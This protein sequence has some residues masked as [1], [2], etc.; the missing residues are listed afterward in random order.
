[1]EGAAASKRSGLGAA[2]SFSQEDE[3]KIVADGGQDDIRRIAVAAPE[4]AAA[5][6][7]VGLHMPIAGS[8]AERRLSSRLM[9]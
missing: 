5:E 1:M 3:A 6:V 8:M 9:W 2:R 4:M 7:S